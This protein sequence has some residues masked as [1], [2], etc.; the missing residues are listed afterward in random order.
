MYAIETHKVCK[1]KFIMKNSVRNFTYS[2]Y[3]VRRGPLD[4]SLQP[5]W[6]KWNSEKSTV[7]RECVVLVYWGCLIQIPLKITIL[8]FDL[9]RIWSSVIVPPW[10]LIGFCQKEHRALLLSI[11]SVE[12]FHAEE[13]DK[14]RIHYSQHLS[15]NLGWASQQMK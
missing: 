9:R 15:E 10:D 11:D 6:W 13:L 1:T 8:C 12:C 4:D 3:C 7:P 14:I 5:T 2:N